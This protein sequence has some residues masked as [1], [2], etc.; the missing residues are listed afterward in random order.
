MYRDFD[1]EILMTVSN[2]SCTTNTLCRSCEKE[3]Y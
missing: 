2:C 3:Q 1:N